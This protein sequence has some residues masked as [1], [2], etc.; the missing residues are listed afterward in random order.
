MKRFEMELT[1]EI[2]RKALGLPVDA[3]AILLAH[4]NGMGSDDA[5]GYARQIITSAWCH[6]EVEFESYSLTDMI[7]TFPLFGTQEEIIDD[8]GGR[9][10]VASWR[11]YRGVTANETHRWVATS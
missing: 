9:E 3:A 8:N 6:G 1:T 7:S 5:I 2:K 10:R 11:T 4:E